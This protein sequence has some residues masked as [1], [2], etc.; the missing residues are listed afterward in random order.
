MKMSMRYSEATVNEVESIVILAS[1]AC[2][3]S[4]CNFRTEGQWSGK[5]LK[6]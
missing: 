2:S 3:L 1:F 6:I 4:Y 5:W